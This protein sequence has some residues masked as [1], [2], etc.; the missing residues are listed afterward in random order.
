MGRPGII[1]FYGDKLLATVRMSDGKQVCKS[2][3]LS[4]GGKCRLAAI[5]NQRKRQKS[6]GFRGLDTIPKAL[7]RSTYLNVPFS[8]LLPDNPDHNMYVI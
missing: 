8:I 7:L 4:D 3:R 1:Y 2:G 6:T 5:G